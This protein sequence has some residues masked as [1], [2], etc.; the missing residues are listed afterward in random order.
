MTAGEHEWKGLDLGTKILR[1]HFTSIRIPTDDMLRLVYHGK[2]SCLFHSLDM[3][4]DEVILSCLMKLY[5][6]FGS[7]GQREEGRFNSLV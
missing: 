5:D 3:T 4:V 1:Y 2:W 7:K 6:R